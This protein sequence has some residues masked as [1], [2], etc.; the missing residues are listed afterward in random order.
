M[1]SCSSIWAV[2]LRHVRMW[3]KDPNHILGTVYWPLQDI[4]IWSFLGAWIQKSG[5]YPFLN[6]EITALLCILLWQVVARG[7]II[8]VTSFTE[9]LWSHNIVNLFSLPLR[10]TEWMMGAVVFSALITSISSLCGILLISYIY[11]LTLGQIITTFLT[12]L[13]PLFFSS[14]W[15]GFTCLLIVLLFGK[16]G[17][18]L[19][20]IISW[21][22][23]PFSG[24]F[25]PIEVLPAIAQKI[26]AYIPMRYVFEGIREHL[27]HQK[28]PTP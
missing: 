25:Y 24:V 21:F 3:Q 28:D 19:G 13:P 27:M 7:S 1:I 6:Y 12:F 17:I 20:Y 14:I 16:R 4:F 11:T 9:E 10:T 15:L 5:A 8:I 26:S 22:F 2:A 18:E 23:A